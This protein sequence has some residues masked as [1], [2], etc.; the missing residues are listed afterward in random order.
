MENPK[1]REVFLTD[2]AQEAMKVIDVPPD[3]EAI[4]NASLETLA[5]ELNR[6]V[7]NITYSELQRLRGNV[8]SDEN[9]V[10]CA[11]RDQLTQLCTDIASE[12]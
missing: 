2:G 10:I 7:L 8:G 11:A 1:S 4:R 12:G 6:R 3:D 9:Q 5:R